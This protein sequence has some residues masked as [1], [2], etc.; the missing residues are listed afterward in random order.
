M[1]ISFKLYTLPKFGPISSAISFFVGIKDQ[2]A[3]GEPVN[4]EQLTNW[5]AEIT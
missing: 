5:I 4:V 2:E 3:T 1:E